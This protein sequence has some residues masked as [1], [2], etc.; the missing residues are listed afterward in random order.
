MSDTKIEAR[1]DS[2]EKVNALLIDYLRGSF[3]SW[4]HPASLEAAMEESALEWSTK[5]NEETTK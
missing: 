5:P 1:L 4:E 2:I 3:A